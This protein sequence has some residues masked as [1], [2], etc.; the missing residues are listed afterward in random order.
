MLLEYIKN[1]QE[2]LKSSVKNR[3]LTFNSNQ[4]GKKNL[5]AYLAGLIEGD[6]TIAVHDFNSMAKK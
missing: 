1:N 2:L 6:G 5:G 4:N 3:S